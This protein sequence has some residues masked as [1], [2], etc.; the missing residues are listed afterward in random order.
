MEGLV[1]CPVHYF[2]ACHCSLCHAFTVTNI[3]YDVNK[4]ANQSLYLM[5]FSFSNSDHLNSFILNCRKLKK[6]HA[7]N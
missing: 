7:L 2:V 1:W 3:T 4:K 6:K 5:N